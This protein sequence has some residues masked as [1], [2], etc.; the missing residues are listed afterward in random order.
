[1]EFPSDHNRQQNVHLYD[2]ANFRHTAHTVV[3]FTIG[4][5]ELSIV[6]IWLISFEYLMI[7]LNGYHGIANS[8]D[9]DQTAIWSGSALFAQACLSEYLE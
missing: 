9:Y 6:P 8:V 5:S 2:N 4:A 1:M 3:I 7:C